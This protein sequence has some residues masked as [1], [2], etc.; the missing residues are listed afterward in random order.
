MKI[1]SPIERL[2]QNPGGLRLSIDA[3]CFDCIYDPA[4]GGLGSWRRQIAE[5][6]VQTCPLYPVRAKRTKK[7]NIEQEG[8]A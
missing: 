7:C 8:D 3:K 4:D 6:T 5:C 1:I 2:S